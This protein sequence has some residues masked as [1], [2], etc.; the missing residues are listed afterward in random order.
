MVA[1]VP[2]SLRLTSELRFASESEPHHD[3]SVGDMRLPVSPSHGDRDRHGDG[4]NSAR[5]EIQLLGRG[6]PGDS[7]DNQ[8]ILP[9]CQVDSDFRFRSLVP[10]KQPCLQLTRTEALAASP[11][12]SELATQRPSWPG[13]S[14]PG[15]KFRASAKTT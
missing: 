10:G 14:R 11:G 6:G 12:P 2:R 15:F 5:L 7:N 1:C 13:R 4:S 9:L 3:D 8:I